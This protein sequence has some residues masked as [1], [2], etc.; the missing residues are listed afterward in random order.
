MTRPEDLQKAIEN[1]CYKV[2]SFD[3]FDTLVLRPSIFPT[4]LFTIVG[5]ECGTDDSFATIRR[6]CESQA[7]KNLI[8]GEEEILYSDIYNV[9][10]NCYNFSDE[11]IEKISQKELDCEYSLLSAR[12]SAKRLFEL[13]KSLG[14]KVIV[15]SDIYL[16]YSFISGMLSHCGY[17]GYDKLYLSSEYKLTKSSG[18]LY[19]VVISDLREQGIEPSEVLHIGDNERSDIASAKRQGLSAM[20]ISRVEAIANVDVTFRRLRS[21]ADRR[22]DNTFPLGFGINRIYDDYDKVPSVN[23][24]NCFISSKTA[25]VEV[26]LAPLVL[27]YA[28]WLVD[29]CVRCGK[30]SVVFINN[31]G[32]LLE[33]IIRK[34]SEYIAPDLDIVRCA[35]DY[36]IRKIAKCTVSD[37]IGSKINSGMTLKEFVYNFTGVSL[38]SSDISIARKYGYRTIEDKID[39]VAHYLPLINDMVVMKNADRDNRIAALKSDC[40]ALF[41][42]SN[43]IFTTRYADVLREVLQD[44]DPETSVYTVFAESTAQIYDIRAMV[45]FGTISSRDLNN[46]RHL[47]ENLMDMSPECLS[48]SVDDTD[49]ICSEV[50]DYAEKFCDLFGYRLKYLRLDSY[51]IYE[52]I[53]ISYYEYKDFILKKIIQV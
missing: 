47:I 37:I 49:N 17:E 45:Q 27:S 23:N 8:V 5:R 24:K 51:Q 36:D 46:I 35:I 30:S 16:P 26:L 15:V 2:I 6:N 7:R 39:S 3:I 50:L 20:Q 9:M 41:D 4:D 32:L 28:K 31:E 12:K 10:K 34:I 14:K 25:V 33:K 21:F 22:C 29:E 40:P 11:D 13:A 53:R 42:D 43:L 38:E 19:Q 1:P 18:R 44:V 48:E 52:Y